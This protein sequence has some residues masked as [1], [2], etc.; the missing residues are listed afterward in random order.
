[1]AIRSALAVVGTLV[2]MS[3][4]AAGAPVRS[5]ASLTVL[6]IERVTDGRRGAHPTLGLLIRADDAGGGNPGVSLG[7][8]S[9][10]IDR[11]QLDVRALAAL[12]DGPAGTRFGWVTISANGPT[13]VQS[14]VRT[15]PGS[16]GNVLTAAFDVPREFAGIVGKSGPVRIRTDTS[17]VTFT[18]DFRSLV[19]RWRRATRREVPWAGGLIG[20]YLDSYVDGR[21]TRYLATNPRRPTALVLD[22]TA[23]ACAD[24]PCSILAEPVS[25]RLTLSL[26]HPVTIRPP[27]RAVY[28]RPAVFSGTGSPGD[29]VHLA[30]VKEPRRKPVCTPTTYAKEPPCSPPFGYAFDRL[31]PTASVR[32]NGTWRL[33]VA[34]RTVGRSAIGLSHVASGR[35]AAVAYR[36][37][38]P[39]NYPSFNGGRFSVFAVP[40]LR[41]EV[42]L[43]RPRV[44]VHPAGSRPLLEIS[45]PGGDSFV[46][47]L[48]SAGGKRLATARLDS[49]GRAKVRVNVPRRRQRLVVTTAA[50][51]AI[52]S[53]TTVSVP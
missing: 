16:F 7:Q 25:D 49:A 1:M 32:A 17:N 15:T 4:A 34:L 20:I 50:P 38:R 14:A 21:R 45:V 22:A 2:A 11:R 23:Q 51:G 35:Y 28:G 27:A 39:A 9:L 46:T 52:A 48:A 3:Q 42:V 8:L 10:T 26:P 30:Y 13:S 6:A 33:A 24:F 19:E 47:V 31:F 5:E 41:I 29:T 37:R 18:L 44:R 43:A 40:A 12:R 53:R 36:G